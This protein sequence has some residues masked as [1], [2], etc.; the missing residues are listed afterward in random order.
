[1][2]QILFRVF[3]GIVLAGVVV[4]VVMNAYYDI[5]ARGN[6]DAVLQDLATLAREGNAQKLLERQFVKTLVLEDEMPL[7]QLYSLLEDT[8]RFALLVR[9]VPNTTPKFSTV[10]SEQR[11]AIS[12]KVGLFDENGN[13]RFSFTAVMWN[14]LDNDENEHWI[15]RSWRDPDIA[16]ENYASRLE[17]AV[18]REEL[19]IRLHDKLLNPEGS[20]HFLNARRKQKSLLAE[21]TRLKTATDIL[22]LYKPK[23]ALL[24]ELESF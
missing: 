9:Q 22:S 1:V 20:V 14:R 24:S 10:W 12:G 18:D 11:F 23:G 19:L 13:N 3:F 15:L 5:S 4:G 7:P 2:Q 21:L 16:A 8:L 17:K 6:I